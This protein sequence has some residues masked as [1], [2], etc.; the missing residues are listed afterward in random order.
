MNESVIKE[1]LFCKSNVL[2]KH[3]LETQ[4]CTVERTTKICGMKYFSFCLFQVCWEVIKLYDKSTYRCSRAQDLF[5]FALWWWSCTVLCAVVQSP[6]SNGHIHMLYNSKS[7]IIIQSLRLKVILEEKTIPIFCW[8]KWEVSK[9]V[10][11]YSSF[12]PN[13]KHARNLSWSR[14]V[15]FTLVLFTYSVFLSNM[16]IKHLETAWKET[17]L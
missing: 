3:I 10:W 8:E 6:L 4:K 2:I 11:Q 15:G 14:P 9:T 5:T 1:P 13:R 12:L 16:D 7:R 17:V